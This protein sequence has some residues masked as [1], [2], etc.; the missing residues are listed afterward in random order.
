MIPFSKKNI[1]KEE[2]FVW[3]LVRTHTEHR[4]RRHR[5]LETHLI[6]FCGKEKHNAKI[7]SI[8]LSEFDEKSQNYSSIKVHV[9]W[10]LAVLVSSSVSS[11]EILAMLTYSLLNGFLYL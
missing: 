2:A 7:L 6:K 4:Y 1:L 10:S 11:P 9:R 8:Y 3:L 5:L